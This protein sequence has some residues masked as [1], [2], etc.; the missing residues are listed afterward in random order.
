MVGRSWR[1]AETVADCNDGGRAAT[2][3]G[4]CGWWLW[5]ALLLH[6]YWWMLGEGPRRSNSDDDV[7]WWWVTTGWRRLSVWLYT[8]LISRNNRRLFSLNPPT[9]HSST[10]LQLRISGATLLHL[11]ISVATL[12]YL[13][14]H[15][16]TADVAPGCLDFRNHPSNMDLQGIDQ[17]PVVVISF[18]LHVQEQI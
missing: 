4:G 17:L 7:W 12:R 15:R 3:M 10:A 11:R 2:A 9:L 14:R 13:Q 16:R 6:F 1:T 8:I 5:A 18:H